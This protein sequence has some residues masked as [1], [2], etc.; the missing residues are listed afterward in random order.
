MKLV[1]SLLR[2]VS[3]AAGLAATATTGSAQILDVR[4]L[5]T[6]Q[7]AALDRS[8]TVAVLV[9]GILEEHGPYLPAWTDGYQ[10]EFVAQRVAEA[11][12]SRRGWTVLRFPAL[13]LGAS[14]ANEIGGRF[15]FPGS[16]PI[17]AETLRAVVMDLAT[18]LGEGGFKYVVLLNYHGAPSHNRALDEASRYFEDSYH[19][20]MLHV[21]GLASFQGAVPRDVFSDAE[22]KREGVSVHADAD[23]HSRMFFLRPDLVAKDVGS[24]PPLVGH[25]IGELRALARGDSWTGY[26]GTPAIANAAAGSRAM[27]ALA[28]AAVESVRQMLD[29]GPPAAAPRAVDELETIPGVREIVEGSAKHDREVEQREREWLAKQPR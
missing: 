17:R 20:R 7:I 1:L 2:T 12:V 15:S 28:Q 21:S 3:C 16:Y 22:R 13:P 18:D 24:A 11:I 10:T 9:G 27:A 5:N 6:R 4:E 25:D 14:P 8:R 19:G 29:G 23:E 26:F